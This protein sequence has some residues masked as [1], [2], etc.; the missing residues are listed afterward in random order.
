MLA[1]RPVRPLRQLF[2]ATLVIAMTVAACGGSQ[3]DMEPAA[4]N[5][6]PS[7]ISEAGS[8]SSSLATP[9]LPDAEATEDHDDTASPKVATPVPLIG[10]SDAAADATMPAQSAS[11]RTT[12]LPP[13]PIGFPA[14]TV[15]VT[16]PLRL[17][18]DALGVDASITTSGVDPDGNFEVP[19]AELVGW[20]EFGPA[21]GEQGS[22]VLAA[23][24]AFDGVD[25]VFRNL[26]QLEVGSVVS[27]ID[28][29]GT[30]RAYR[31]VSRE[32]YDKEALPEDVFRR[33]GDE[34]LVLITCGGD[35]NPS[36]RS[37]D[38]N[39]VVVAVPV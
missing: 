3:A 7:A 8:A 1:L 21:P 29:S 28:A 30:Q 20:Y 39:V 14:T 32:R 16:A 19:P 35:F 6:S 36:L 17:T 25:G 9:M 34:Q 15:E 10:P 31:T 13:A 11:Q 4:D 33:D 2:F 37:Y 22:T 27:V 24:I 18:I 26:D 23:H 5:P 12:P 38:D